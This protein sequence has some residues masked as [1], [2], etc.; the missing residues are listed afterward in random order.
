MHRLLPRLETAAFFCF[1][2]LLSLSAGQMLFADT[3]TYWHLA[4]GR[5]LLEHGELPDHDPWAFTT[6]THPWYLLSWLWNVMLG[7]AYAWQGLFGA[8]YMSALVHAAAFTVCFAVCR[9]RSGDPI[10][11]F[12]TLLLVMIPIGLYV[13]PQMMTVLLVPVFAWVLQKATTERRW[14]L[15][16]ALPLLTALWVNLHGGFGAGL[17]LIGCYGLAAFLQRDRSLFFV[18][19]ATGLACAGA[20][21]LNPYGWSIFAG[22][23]RTMGGFLSQTIIDEWKPLQ[24]TIPSLLPRLFIPLFL[25]LVPPRDRR[26]TLGER[27]AAYGWLLLGLSSARHL[28]IFYLVAA[29]MLAVAIKDSLLQTAPAGSRGAALAERLRSGADRRSVRSIAVAIAL[30]VAG[31]L[32]TAPARARLQADQWHMQMPLD[33]TLAYLRAHCRQPRLLTHYNVGSYFVFAAPG[34]IRPFID[35]RAETAYPPGTLKDYLAFHQANVGWETILDTWHIDGVLLPAAELLPGFADRFAHRRGWHL[36]HR[37]QFAD[38]YLRDGQRAC[39]A[40]PRKE[41]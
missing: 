8:V 24:L 20:A 7:H 34:E 32:Q 23:L 4:A 36:A 30:I 5:L 21:L 39:T 18:L 12:L 29:P 9:E 10:P 33:D 38:L 3:D 25:V 40:M 14:R 1:A 15:L 19:A 41:G 35:G 2:L 37:G 17:T 22:M 13:R 31:A 28:A 27:I 26:F 11:A 6:G 16:A